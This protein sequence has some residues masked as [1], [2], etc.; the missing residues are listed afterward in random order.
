MSNF[1]KIYIVIDTRWNVVETVWD[2]REKAEGA[3]GALARDKNMPRQYIEIIERKI[4]DPRT[5]KGDDE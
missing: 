4:N 5:P 1:I 3:R 2:S